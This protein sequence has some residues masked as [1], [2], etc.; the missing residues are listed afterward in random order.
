MV[1]FW[2][3]S[4]ILAE[5]PSLRKGSSKVK[6]LPQNKL[7]LKKACL[8][9]WHISCFLKRAQRTGAFG[10]QSADT[11]PIKTQVLEKQLPALGERV[12]EGGSQTSGQTSSPA[13]DGK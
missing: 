10:G 2:L 1:Q 13:P 3:L 6:Q 9:G 5:F 12:Q 7:N 8:E 4:G 11:G